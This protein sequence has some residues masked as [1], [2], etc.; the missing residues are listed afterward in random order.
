MCLHQLDNVSGLLIGKENS[1]QKNNHHDIAREMR[2]SCVDVDHLMTGQWLVGCR[3]VAPGAQHCQRELACTA[4]PL[5]SERMAPPV[6]TSIG[7]IF[8][9]NCP[10]VLLVCGLALVGIND[11]TSWASWIVEAGRKSHEENSQNFQEIVQ[12]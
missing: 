10:R 8:M 4:P 6:A 7:E 11:E 5:V 3:G 9:C 1:L 2:Q 12:D